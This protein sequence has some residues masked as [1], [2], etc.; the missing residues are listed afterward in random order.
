MRVNFQMPPGSK[1]DA[2]DTN[3]TKGH[4]ISSVLEENVVAAEIQLSDNEFDTLS[5]ARS[6]G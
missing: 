1:L 3:P 6:A 4:Y 2:V 5:R